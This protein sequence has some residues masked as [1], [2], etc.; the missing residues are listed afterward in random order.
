MHMARRPL[1]VRAARRPTSRRDDHRE[2]I[3]RD[4]LANKPEALEIGKERSQ[5]HVVL[6]LSRAGG[7]KECR[8]PGQRLGSTSPSLRKS[9][10]AAHIT[11][12]TI[13]GVQEGSVWLWLGA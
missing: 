10:D 7:W 1:A 4:L 5:M 12:C 9:L 13:G 8:R 11:S 3:S 2:G 6:V